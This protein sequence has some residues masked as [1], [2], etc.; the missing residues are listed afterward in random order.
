M[1][2]SEDLSREL[3]TVGISGR[4]RSRIIDEFNDHLAC[5][6]DAKLGEP[7]AIAR[8]FAD[9]VGTSRARR[10]G[11]IS[12][13]AL[14]LAGILFGLAFVIPPEGPLVYATRTSHISWLVTFAG[15]VAVFAAQIALAAGVLAALRAIRHRRDGVIAGAEAEV[16]TRR[17][18]VG[19]IAGIVTMAALGGLA[20]ALR[21]HVAGWWVTMTVAFAIAAIVGLVAALPAIVAALRVHP[22]AS[23]EAGD[24]FDDLGRWAP[25]PL[26]GHPWRLAF[27]VAAAIVV[28][29]TA[30]GVAKSDGFDGALRGVA[31]AVVCL[32]LFASLGHWLG[33]WRRAP[34]AASS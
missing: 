32:L 28:M 29:L 7:H 25:R 26:R 8:Q 17:A 19:L 11:Y 3:A 18:A 34:D 2:Y 1:S 5:D 13:G 6:P 22:V 12:F 31:D 24:I 33:L 23:G 15:A 20:L 27:L 9:E 21:G 30:A 14:V 10:A 4:L 16:L